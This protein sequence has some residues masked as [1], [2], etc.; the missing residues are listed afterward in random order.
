MTLR[1]STFDS[2]GASMFRPRALASP[3]AHS[4][5]HIAT[6]LLL[7]QADRSDRFR[8]VACSCSTTLA[9]A[10]VATA[11]SRRHVPRRPSVLFGMTRVCNR[12]G[13]R[14]AEAYALSRWCWRQWGIYHFNRK[15]KVKSSGQ[16]CPVH[17]GNVNVKGC[18]QGVR[19]T[20]ALA[21]AGFRACLRHAVVPSLLAYPP[22]N[23]R[24]I[25]GRSLRDL[26]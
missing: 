5:H 19:S 1:M 10:R 2:E 6:G 12:V 7:C 24:A 22:V 4:G 16:E 23:W 14:G 21:L 25:F 13:L 18:G 15:V 26:N 17:T 9:G 11:E 3:R 8:P 20:W